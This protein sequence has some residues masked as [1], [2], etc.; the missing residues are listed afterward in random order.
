MR[1]ILLKCKSQS[2]S[3]PALKTSLQRSNK[4]EKNNLSQNKNNKM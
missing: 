4:Q 3:R 2:S 1:R